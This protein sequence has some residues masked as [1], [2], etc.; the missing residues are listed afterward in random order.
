MNRRD[1]LAGLAATPLLT[2]P[3]IAQDAVLGEVSK[4][5]NQLRVVR[6]RFTQVNANGSRS[7]GDYYWRRP[8]LIRFEYGRSGAMVIADGTN[9]AVFD[10][11]SNSG[12][13]RYP[14]RTT[15][16]RFLLQEQ[17]DLTRDNL[18]AGA[19]TKQGFTYVTLRDPSKPKDGTMTLALQNQPPTLRQWTVDE[20]NGRRTTVVLDTLEQV[21]SLDLKLFNIE[22]EA[23]R[24]QRGR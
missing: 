22:A 18:A 15:P 9:V 24:L 3:A 1:F 12:V 16:L 6:G 21:S 7:A 13:Q 17:I 11:K 19:Q 8:G 14:L 23:Q 4:Y 20:P 10:P 5:L 2:S